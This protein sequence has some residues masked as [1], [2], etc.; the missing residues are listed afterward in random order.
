MDMLK[1][2]GKD[3]DEGKLPDNV[4]EYRYAILFIIY[5]TQYFYKG[6]RVY[7]Q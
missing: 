5:I 2:W 7:T 6:F 4:L 3:L 1:V